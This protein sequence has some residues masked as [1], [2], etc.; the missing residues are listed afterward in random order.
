MNFKDLT[1]E[2]LQ[3]RK[4]ELVTLSETEEDIEKLGAIN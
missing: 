1:V 3:A 4:S 2:Q